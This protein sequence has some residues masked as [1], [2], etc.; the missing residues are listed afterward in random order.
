[1]QKLKLDLESI[2][3]ESFE[4]QQDG[5]T[6]TVGTVRAHDADVRTLPIS[7]CFWSACQTCGIYC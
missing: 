1:M 2:T 7:D 3:V 6:R 5:E 4:A